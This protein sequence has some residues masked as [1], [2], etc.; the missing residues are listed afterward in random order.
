MITKVT[1]PDLRTAAVTA[2]APVVEYL[3]AGRPERTPVAAELTA[4]AALGTRSLPA[5]LRYQRGLRFANREDLAEAERLDPGWAHVR[6]ARLYTAALYGDA[7]PPAERPVDPMRDPSGHVL[8]G[9]YGGVRPD[10]ARVATEVPL[11]LCGA[12][13]ELCRQIRIA[14]AAQDEAQG[15]VEAKQLCGATF[16]DYSAC[17]DVYAG[18]ARAELGDAAREF[19]GAWARV[20]PHHVEALA[21]DAHSRVVAGDVDGARAVS[22][23]LRVLDRHGTHE[24]RAGIYLAADD[25]TAALR[26]LMPEGAPIG[27]RFDYLIAVTLVAMGKLD[28]ATGVLRLAEESPTRDDV[29]EALIDIDV[30]R[31]APELAA[32][33]IDRWLASSTPPGSYAQIVRRYQR[34]RLRGVKPCPDIEAMIADIEDAGMRALVAQA[35]RREGASAGC[36]PCKHVMNDGFGSNQRGSSNLAFAR[37]AIREGQLDIARRVLERT[38]ML[39]RPDMQG[40]ISPFSSMV[41]RYELARVYAAQGRTDDARRELDVL[42]ERWQHADRPLA[43]VE[44]ARRLR[45]SLR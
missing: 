6:A 39:I 9:L 11:K 3:A 31:G 19:A 8:V 30:G 24:F 2:T 13:D 40:V 18:L 36:A 10:P 5:Y 43:T 7:P 21:A 34:D 28:Q 4:M 33:T 16:A 25:L 23:Q 26:V 1:E 37:C 32:A 41:A 27:R 14:Y 17:N 20:K 35:L 42:I 29:F 45:A 15:F 12:Y 44:D 22:E 38:R